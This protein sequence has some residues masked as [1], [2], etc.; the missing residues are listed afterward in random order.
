MKRHLM[1]LFVGLVAFA[2]A[3]SNALLQP[4]RTS[5]VWFTKGF[6][7][8]IQPRAFTTEGTLRAA[9]E[10]L[11]DLKELGVT[12]VYL[13]P[14]FEMDTDVDRSFWSPRQIKSGFDN[15][16]NQYR[17]RDYF[18]VDSEYG[19]DDDLGDGLSPGRG[20]RRRNAGR[21]LP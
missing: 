9:A 18:H 20:L 15:P 7:Y 16:K 19:T 12:I 14:V 10:R 21:L 17:I 11:D 6:M 3:A 1:C 5:P 13:L 2:G 8:Q 4:A